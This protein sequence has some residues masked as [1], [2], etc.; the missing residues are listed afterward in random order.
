M[1]ALI[2]AVFGASLLGSAHCAG[3]CGAFLAFA[4]QPATTE[5]AGGP[6]RRVSPFSLQSG[7]HLGRLMTYA[8]LGAAAGALGAAIDFGGR[9]AGVQRAALLGAGAL[10]VLFGVVAVL[11]QV[12]MSLPHAPLPMA[13][14]K[15]VAAGQR[16]AF[17]MPP[18][19]RAWAIGLLTPMLPCGWLYAFAVLAAGTGHPGAGALTMAVFWAG[20]L[21]MLIGLGVGIQAFT[22]VLRARLPMLT[23]LA[24]IAVGLWTLSGRM[25]MVGIAQAQQTNTITDA[26]GSAVIWMQS[27]AACHGK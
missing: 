22:G 27:G 17:E 9:A 4:V 10:M 12:G 1:T 26:D 6:A 13:W 19:P 15:A 18:L 21:P 11:R 5:G 2:I 20:T 7:Y 14:R 8:L 23:S 25:P 3:M 24:V 16:F